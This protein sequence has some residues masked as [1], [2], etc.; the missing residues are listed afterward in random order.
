MLRTVFTVGALILTTATL[1]ACNNG[2]TISLAP[3]AQ[4]ALL[5]LEGDVR[6]LE[7]RAGVLHLEATCDV[8]VDALCGA[9]AAQWCGDSPQVYDLQTYQTS[10][11]GEARTVW[12]AQCQPRGPR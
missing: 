3:K 9:T 4:V 7:L 10:A 2:R 8:E 5:P 1:L 11:Q 12:L 6:P